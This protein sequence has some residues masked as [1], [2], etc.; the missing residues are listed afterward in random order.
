DGNPVEPVSARHRDHAAATRKAMGPSLAKARQQARRRTERE[1]R[2]RWRATPAPVVEVK[3][4]G[5]RR[6][7][8]PGGA[9]QGA[10]ASLRDRLGIAARL[11]LG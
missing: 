5:R 6:L 2:S 3:Q 10:V 7:A 11:S 1:A 9:G 8:A 4:A